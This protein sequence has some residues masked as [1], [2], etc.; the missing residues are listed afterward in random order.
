MFFYAYED[1]GSTFRDF[2]I[3]VSSKLVDQTAMAS[4]GS[5]EYLQSYIYSRFMSWAT[6]TAAKSTPKFALANFSA[7][8]PNSMG[9]GMQMA[10][11]PRSYLSGYRQSTVPYQTAVRFNGSDD[12]FSFTVG[13]GDGAAVMGSQ[14]GFGLATDYDPYLGGA[15][16]LLGFASGGA[17]AQSSVKLGAHWTVAAGLTERTLKRDL[18]RLD[19]LQHVA[20]GSIDPAQTGAQSL[21]VTYAVSDA[22]SFNLGYTRL[23]EDK[24]LLGV[25]SLDPN[26]FADGATTDGISVGANAQLTPTLSLTAAGTTARTRANDQGGSFAIAGGGLASTS[27]QV[28][29]V[30]EKL[31]V[32]NDSLRLTVAQPMHMENGGID[33]TSVQVV[34]RQT[35]ELGAVTQRFGITAPRRQFVG[36]MQY[37]LGSASDL[38]VSLFG[39]AKLQGQATDMLPDLMAGAGFRLAL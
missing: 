5:M 8:V 20:L 3:P 13:E 17:Y 15:N 21:T 33:Y 32:G 29:M 9:L 1:I 19:F 12:R 22:V 35:G 34:N 11:A 26:D 39:R 14:N 31:L 16:P 6:A 4:T 28:A 7:S 10:I 18:D 37:R 27:F 25:Q 23:R 24:A 38:Q 36:E 2:A 30:K